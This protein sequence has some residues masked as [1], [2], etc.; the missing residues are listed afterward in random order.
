MYILK[1][2]VLVKINLTW[3]IGIGNAHHCQFD[4]SQLSQLSRFVSA[5][6]SWL[7]G[8]IGIGNAHHCDAVTRKY[9][10]YYVSKKA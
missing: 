2:I 5:D 8:L 1:G 7:I 9:D 3:L 10:S 6:L 4:L